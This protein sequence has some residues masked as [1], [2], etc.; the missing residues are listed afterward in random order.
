MAHDENAHG[1]A[2][3]KQDKAVLFLRMFRVGNNPG[4]FVEKGMTCFLE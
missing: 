3:A 2:H 4:I 1:C